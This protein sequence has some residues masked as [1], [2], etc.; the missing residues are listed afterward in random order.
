MRN[1]RTVRLP[2]QP[3]LVLRILLDRAGEVVTREVLQGQLWS[4]VAFGDFD[5]GLNKAVGK[6]R[7][8]LQLLE[9]DSNLIQT[10][11]RRGY[12]VNAEVDW[13][14]PP[15]RPISV[16]EARPVEQPSSS[17]GPDKAGF[18]LGMG[19]A[20][21]LLLGA[22][23][24]ASHLSSGLYRSSPAPAIRSLAVLPLINLSRNPDEEYLADGITEELSTDLSHA[25]SLRVISRAST[26]GFQGSRLSIPE[27]AEQLHVDA[28]IEGT[29]CVPTTPFAPPSGSLP[30]S[31]SGR[32]GR[33]PTSGADPRFDAIV[34]KTGLY[35]N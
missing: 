29:C 9:G 31:P 12:R 11:P 33:P 21:A 26:S 4:D 20:P 35:D 23:I 10:I 6:L 30:P 17:A 2:A 16:A 22:G 24:A 5:N 25:K 14:G 18:W 34:K 3:L 19:L 13:I 15:I 27:I 28:V 32:Y 1:G 7:D 8:A